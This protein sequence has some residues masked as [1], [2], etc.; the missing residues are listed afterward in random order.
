MKE[1]FETACRFIGA[2]VF[3]LSIMS[4]PVTATALWI[5]EI[6]NIAVPIFI[7]MTGIE[8]IILGWFLFSI[9]S[10]NETKKITKK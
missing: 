3:S 6:N 8:F 1:K 2:L 9:T 4:V 10:M 5:M 7:V